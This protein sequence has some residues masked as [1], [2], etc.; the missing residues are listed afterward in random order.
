MAASVAK[1]VISATGTLTPTSRSSAAVCTSFASRKLL[2]ST[3]RQHRLHD[4][5]E[6]RR[7]PAGEDDLRDLAS[8]QRVETGLPHLVVSGVARSRERV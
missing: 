8:A 1:L 3:A 7:H 5:A 2:P 4:A 6:A